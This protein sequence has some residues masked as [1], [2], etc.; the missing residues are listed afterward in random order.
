MDRLFR[1]SA[2]YREKW[3][4]PAGGGHSYGEVTIWHATEKVPARKVR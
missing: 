2:R 1:Q 4:Q 3:G